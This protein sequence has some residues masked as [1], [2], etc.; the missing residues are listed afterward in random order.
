M[1]ETTETLI[2]DIQFD[3]AQAIKEAT[4][5]KNKIAELKVENKALLES[6]GK[7][8]DAYV[9]NEIQIKALSKE[10]NANQQTLV[11]SVQVN[12]EAEGSNNKLRATLSV[13][14]AQYN[15]LS[16]EERDNSVAGQVLSKSIKNISDELKSTEGAVGDFRRNVGDYEGAA[17]RASNSLQ[18][19]KER[20]A[21]LNKVVQTSEVG[22]K[23]FKDAQD[24]AG[25]LGLA[26]GQVEGKLDEF[27][28][29][30]PK[31]PA[32]KSFDDTVQ[33]A[34][35]AASAVQLSS[36]IFD[37]NSAA[38][39]SLAKSVKALAIG[40]QVAN[41]VK[42]KGAIID[43]VAAAST[44]LAAGA[45]TAYT[46]AVGTSTGA[47]K[48]FRLALAATG[49]GAI[50]VGL[51]L[52]IANFDA[53]SG[54]V[55]KFLGLA[56]DEELA[57]EKLKEAYKGEADQLGFLLSL[58]ERRISTVDGLYQ[59]QINLLKAQGRSTDDLEN[60]QAEYHKR[61]LDR[62][63]ESIQALLNKQSKFKTSV[64]EEQDLRQLLADKQNELANEQ[65]AIEVRRLEAIKK[66]KDEAIKASKEQADKNKA[67]L[68]KRKADNEKAAADELKLQQELAKARLE[69]LD[70][71]ENKEILI[72][73][74]AAAERI[75]AINGTGATAEALRVTIA[76]ET[77]QQ[78][79]AIR[80]KYADEAIAK[81]Q[82]I[83]DK[84]KQLQ[85]ERQQREADEFV[86]RQN[87]ILDQANFEFAQ[88]QLGISNED[89]K[90]IK[91]VEGLNALVAIQQQTGQTRAQI[92]QDYYDFVERNG[93]IS[94]EQFVDLQARQVEAQ[95]AA[96][97]QLISAYSAFGAQVGDI[98]AQA[99][100]QQ[101]GELKAFGRKFIILI[102]DVLQKQVTA[103]IVS[104]TAQSFA[105]ADSVASF[106]ATGGIRAAI[107]TAAIQG[108]F[109]L[110][111]AKLSEQPKGFATGVVGLQGEG[112]STSDSIPAWLSAGESVVTAEGTNYAQTYMP[113]LLEFLNTKNKFATGV[114]NFQGS[115]S[116][117]DMNGFA[118]IA[119]AISKMQPVVKVSDINK[120][121]SDYSE[122]RVTGTI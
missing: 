33:A 83:Y 34:G 63:I 74:N 44:G 86:R 47:L 80:A 42:E 38:A 120:K 9:K 99:L 19:M 111:K 96:N 110:A 101:G 18:G 100:D 92:D 97:Q 14:T 72:A 118:V 27:G 22:S 24:E 6:E 39:E 41:I 55:K 20:L 107:L 1:A 12:K 4:D 108:A 112:T 7:V 75:A 3:S 40:Q 56:T 5:L 35:A 46:V 28:N 60:K 11:K 98:F 76:Q 121:Q 114:V 94:F 119:D 68:E 57:S 48:A 122:V 106:G 30:E 70:D 45:T 25:K 95:A 85:A 104:S 113:G 88:Q 31:N 65:N 102:L 64:K 16:K 117:A 10:L 90:F 69:L 67:A 91:T 73:Q 62:S 32:K 43:T 51:G 93:E 17:N 66:N 52:L 58:T 77:E 79:A 26:I 36:L 71:G 78:I 115:Q 109:G 29:K 82:E 15:A 61:E 8:T 84:E 53:V 13:L 87:A 105:Q 89:A 2:L 81:Q 59:R 37:E 116:V 21:E 54:A 49:I 103:A 23:Q 50:I